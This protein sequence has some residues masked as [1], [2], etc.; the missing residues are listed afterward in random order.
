[1]DEVVGVCRKTVNGHIK[2][3]CSNGVLQSTEYQSST[4][5]TGTS[6]VVYRKFNGDSLGLRATTC[7]GYYQYDGDISYYQLVGTCTAARLGTVKED[8]DAVVVEE[9]ADA[10]AVNE[11]AAAVADGDADAGAVKEDADASANGDAVSS[12]QPIVAP[13][14]SLLVALASMSHIFI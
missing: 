12:G 11:D 9:A 7:Q 10:V 8:A 1:L 14:F 13:P 3:T 5:C 6:R 2:S 4:G